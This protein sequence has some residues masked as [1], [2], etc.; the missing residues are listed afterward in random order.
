MQI[1]PLKVE[2]VPPFA[3]NIMGI[4]E[5]LKTSSEI[6]NQMK[7]SWTPVHAS[8][9][10]NKIMRLPTKDRAERH[11]LKSRFLLLILLFFIPLRREEK[12]G[13]E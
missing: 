11:D 10:I 13:K 8:D 3:F 7:K 4:C 9:P 12:R 5:R 6:L 1:Y 2:S